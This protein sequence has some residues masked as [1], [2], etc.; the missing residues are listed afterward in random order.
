MVVVKVELTDE[1]DRIIDR[2]VAEGRVPSRDDYLQEAIRTYAA[3]L[4]TEDD[5]LAMVDRADADMAAG[6]YKT[7][8]TPAESHAL[9]EA[10]IDRLRARLAEDTLKP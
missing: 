3:Y 9:H 4:D 10:A 7:I 1:L 6:R 8:S 2:R 5:I